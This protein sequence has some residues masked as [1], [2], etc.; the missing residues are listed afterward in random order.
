MMAAT[1]VPAVESVTMLVNVTRVPGAEVNGVVRMKTLDDFLS[2]LR[3]LGK[4]TIHRYNHG[5][6]LFIYPDRWEIVREDSGQYVRFYL[7]GQ[8]VLEL[9]LES[10]Y[11]K[12]HRKPRPDNVVVKCQGCYWINGYEIYWLK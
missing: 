11:L 7:A 1:S 5:V 8:K 9:H 10:E 2:D 6:M 12:V 3:K 4:P